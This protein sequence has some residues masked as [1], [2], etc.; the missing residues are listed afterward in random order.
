MCYRQ[1]TP[2]L[3]GKL[4][5]I[6]LDRPGPKGARNYNLSAVHFPFVYLYTFNLVAKLMYVADTL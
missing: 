2:S 1:K 4:L 6:D 3:Y 5:L